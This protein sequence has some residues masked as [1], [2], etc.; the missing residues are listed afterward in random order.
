MANGATRE[1]LARRRS[2]RPPPSHGATIRWDRG[3]L[4]TSPSMCKVRL[5]PLGAVE[6][7]GPPDS[8]APPPDPQTRLSFRKRLSLAGDFSEAASLATEGSETWSDCGGLAESETSSPFGSPKAAHARAGVAA[9]P[10]SCDVPG[11]MSAAALARI[12]A[13]ALASQ[14]TARRRTTLL[15]AAPASAAL[16]LIT[17]DPPSDRPAGP[18]RAADAA[19]LMPPPVRVQDRLRTWGA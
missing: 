16:P 7:A 14:A 12:Y 4:T 19:L 5:A 8:A 9:A 17:I 1:L 11:K 2:A 3:G 6:L 13:Q 10:I 15:A 18:P